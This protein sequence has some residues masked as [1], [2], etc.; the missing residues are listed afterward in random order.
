MTHDP[1]AYVSTPRVGTRADPEGEFTLVLTAHD[2]LLIKHALA[3]AG[4]VVE[5]RRSAQAA[6]QYDELHDRLQ[7]WNHT[8][9]DSLG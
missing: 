1:Q 4:N 7:D 9:A 5:D 2:Y 8:D 6:A 3:I